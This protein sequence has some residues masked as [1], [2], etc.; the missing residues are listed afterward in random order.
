VGTADSGEGM[1]LATYLKYLNILLLP[2][3][4][5]LLI[6]QLN[7]QSLASSVIKHILPEI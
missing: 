4:F 2:C 6:K 7:L 5:C 1:N 3:S